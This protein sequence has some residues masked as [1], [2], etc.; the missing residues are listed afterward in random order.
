MIPDITREK[1]HQLQ[2]LVGQFND[3]QLARPLE[4]LNGAS[5]GM[6]VRHILEFYQC[7][8][9]AVTHRDLNYDR[10]KR[11]KDME[12][13]TESC[14]ECIS[15]L[16]K[17]ID[18]Y[19]DDFSMQLHADY[20][21]TDGGTPVNVTTTYFRELLYNVEHTVHHLAIIKIGM[22]ALGD[23]FE[24]GDDFGVA[25]STMRNNKLCAQ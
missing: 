8:F 17:Q 19:Q 11:D 10:R 4:V 16:K 13:Q 24:I 21:V 15:F 23:A 12:T 18:R 3:H 20:A 9:E 25:A 2:H 6:H 5:I 14:L 22:Q 1:L 7:L